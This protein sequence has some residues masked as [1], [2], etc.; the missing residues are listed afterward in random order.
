MTQRGVLLRTAK[1]LMDEDL[2][3]GLDRDEEVQSRGRSKVLRELVEAYLRSRREARHDADYRR[4][5]GNEMRVSEELDGW[6]EEGWWPA[7]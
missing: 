6:G 3:A 7:G 2:L 1:I 4:G 5:Y